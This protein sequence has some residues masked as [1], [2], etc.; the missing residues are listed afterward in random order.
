MT[1]LWFLCLMVEI[2][3]TVAVAYVPVVSVKETNAFVPHSYT[4]A[5]HRNIL[6]LQKET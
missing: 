4:R 3:V 5:A 2:M 6:K 1:D